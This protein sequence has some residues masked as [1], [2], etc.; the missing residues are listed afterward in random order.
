MERGQEATEEV[1]AEY[2]LPSMQGA[3]GGNP[4]YASALPGANLTVELKR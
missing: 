2:H 1:P 4:E 3:R